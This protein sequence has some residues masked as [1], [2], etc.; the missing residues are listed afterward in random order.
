MTQELVATT[1]ECLVQDGIEIAKVIL[2]ILIIF[3]VRKSMVGAIRNKMRSIMEKREV[4]P[5][6]RT[7]I[8]NQTLPHEEQQIRNV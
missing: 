8:L 5:A 2:M 7:M 1:T 3:V 4:D 6:A